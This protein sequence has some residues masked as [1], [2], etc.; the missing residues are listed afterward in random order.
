MRTHEGS[1]PPPGFRYTS[2]TNTEWLSVEELRAIADDVEA[3][4]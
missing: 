1:A 3:V 2:D 4:A